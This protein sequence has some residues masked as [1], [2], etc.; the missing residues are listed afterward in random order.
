MSASARASEPSMEEILASIRR[1]IADEVAPEPA[2]VPPAPVA[3]RPTS[4]SARSIPPREMPTRETAVRESSA[5]PLPVRETPLRDVSAREPAP[6]SSRPA[7]VA[8]EPLNGTAHG[9]APSS[10]NGFAAPTPLRPR[11]PVMPVA[12][13]ATRP[14]PPAFSAARPP[15]ESPYS[16]AAPAPGFRSAAA[17]P[18]YVPAGRA[19]AADPFA[20]H[21]RG[22]SGLA[23]ARA[24]PVE[25]PLPA[26]EAVAAPIPESR[27]AASD[28]VAHRPAALKPVVSRAAAD[29][30][31]AP[32]ASVLLDLA[33][34]EQAVQAELAAFEAPKARIAEPVMDAPA[35]SD[36]PAAEAPPAA[37][38]AEMQLQAIKQDVSEPAVSEPAKVEA[39]EARSAD[40]VTP[41]TV[42]P[43]AAEAAPA[44]PAPS[45]PRAFVPSFRTEPRLPES[46]PGAVNRP[47]ATA[48]PATAE[49]PRERL[50]SGPTNNAVT[51]AFSSLHR[52]VMPSARSVDDLVTEALRPMLKS[53]LDENLPSLVER[54]VRA[55]IERVARQGQ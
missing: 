14:V 41:E 47:A 50:V 52:S 31:D 54:L 33:L 51:S 8:R 15:T 16:Y 39:V 24:L 1:I 45:L 10:R 43:E 46:R 19:P 13:T 20:P 23:S 37:E 29:N 44:K 28:P 2:P 22:A 48:E 11:E 6:L 30:L 17:A 7:P 27:P 21:P 3:S 5:R 4:A 49:A 55:E 34:V 26:A 9:P 12:S 25:E 32:L 38:T 40:A 35:A 42:T 18:S 36:A 53:W